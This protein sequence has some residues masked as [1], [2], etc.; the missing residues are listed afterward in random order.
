ML[1]VKWVC[2]L[3]A[4][5]S[6]PVE[7]VIEADP[8]DEALEIDVSCRSVADRSR[9]D[10]LVDRADNGGE[11]ARTLKRGRRWTLRGCDR[12]YRRG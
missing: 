9:A 1:S 5:S 10:E 2:V 4:P 7:V 12:V 11:E 6:A 8:K 3:I